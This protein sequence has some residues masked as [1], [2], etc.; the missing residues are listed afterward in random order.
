MPR[1]TD[2]PND[3]ALTR[4]FDETPRPQSEVYLV[5]SEEERQKGFVRPYRDTYIHCGERPRY[6]LRDL[7]EEERVR[8]AGSNYSKFEAYP[9]SEAPTV[10]SYWTEARLNGGCGTVT[11]MGRALSETYARN[12]R[13]YGAT[14]CVGC[15]M[16]KPVAE[17]RWTADNAVVGS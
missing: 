9:E 11:S 1:I 14:Y 5:L 2:D 17:F 6:P 8:H 10:G 7:T 16:H 13:F 3:P 15:S 12:P 4:G